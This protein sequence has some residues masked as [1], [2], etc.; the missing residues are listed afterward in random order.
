METAEQEKEKDN[1]RVWLEVVDDEIVEYYSDA[2]L[3]KH[4]M[5]AEAGAGNVDQRE[6]GNVLSEAGSDGGVDEVDDASADEIPEEERNP[7]HKIE[8]TPQAAGI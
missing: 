5:F 4:P 6:E 8:A 2:E 3:R 1:E 7:N